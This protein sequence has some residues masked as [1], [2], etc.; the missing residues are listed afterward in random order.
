MSRARDS[1]PT[2]TPTLLVASSASLATKGAPPS[3]STPARS[4]PV[5]HSTAACAP[6]DASQ[7]T[8]T[9]TGSLSTGGPPGER[10]AGI[11]PAMAA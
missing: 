11:V 3:A 8:Q 4:T 10:S 7:N 6:I 5:C 2:T 9:A 1:R